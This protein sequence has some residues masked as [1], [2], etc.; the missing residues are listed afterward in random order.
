MG[1]AFV[2]SLAVKK[3]CAL[4]LVK[5]VKVEWLRLMRDFFCIYRKERIVSRLLGE[6]V[7]FIQARAPYTHLQY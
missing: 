6:F 2:S 3:S 7:A 5:V 4:G 1:I